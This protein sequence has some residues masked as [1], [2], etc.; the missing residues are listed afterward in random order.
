MPRIN[1]YFPIKVS[2]TGSLTDAQLEQLCESLARALAARISYAE[3]EITTRHHLSTPAAKGMVGEPYKLTRGD[4]ENSAYNVPSYQG[5]GRPVSVSVRRQRRP[6]FIRTALN[7][8][9]TVSDFLDLV[10]LMTNNQSQPSAK[11]LYMDRYEELRWVSLWLVQVNQEYTLRELEVILFA[12]ATQLMHLRANQVLAYAMGT[13]E[14]LR[15]KLILLDRDGVVAR[16]I[17]NMQSHNARRVA[18][19]IDEDVIIHPGGWVL[20]A[21]MALPRVE[22][23]DI[24]TYGP[25]VTVWLPLHALAFIVNG[26]SFERLFGVSWNDHL[27]EYGDQLAPLRILPF[28]TQRRAHFQTLE[29][30]VEPN[31]AE[32]VEQTSAYFGGVHLL[33]QSRIDWLPSAARTQARRLTND[34]TLPLDE[35]R[36]EG[37]WEPNWAGAFIYVV[38]NATGDQPIAPEAERTGQ[39]EPSETPAR[40]IARFTRRMNLD[41]A[42]LGAYLVGLIRRSPALSYYVQRVLDELGSSDRDDVSLAFAQSATNDDLDALARSPNGR[43]LLVRLYDELTSGELGADEQQQAGRVLAARVRSRSIEVVTR[44]L[45]RAGRWVFPYRQ[46]GPTVYDDAPIMAERLADGRIRVS[47][48]HR[49]SGTDMFR[50][51]VRTL[52]RAVFS[53]GLVLDAD[54]WISVKLYDEGGIIV[55]RPALYLLE[56]SNQGATRTLHT[57]GNVIATTATL[58]VGGAAQGASWGVRTLVALDRA[59][60]VLSV[61]GIIVNDHRGWLI[62]T[63][64]EDGRTF[65]R[66]VEVAN[67]LAGVYGLGR[68]A[69]STP[70]IIVD[71]RNAWRSWRANRAYSGLQGADLRRAEEL[72]QNVEQFLTRADEAADAMRREASSTPTGAPAPV[73]SQT[74]PPPGSGSAPRPTTS[75]LPGGTGAA[76]GEAPRAVLYRGTTYR[77]MRGRSRDI[78]DLGDGVYMTYDADLAVLYAQERRVLVQATDPGAPGIVLRVEAETGELGRVLDFY[79]DRALRSDWETFV[80]RQ[81]GG[82]IVLRGGPAEMYNGHFQNWLRSR[83]TSLDNFDVIIGPEY[84]RGGSQVCIRNEGIATRLLDRAEEWARA[85]EPVTPAYPAVRAPRVP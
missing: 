44:R 49:V 51:E 52:P 64:G 2:I 9:S 12:R 73:H 74:S 25:E 71:L 24:L 65:V 54:E 77:F 46:G 37:W 33:N 7:F 82:D 13:T 18:A 68:I 83:G 4:A 47:L 26:E 3:R 30:L 27:N 85:H 5:G 56:I 43:L 42:G 69:F 32:T 67:T 75:P 15:R 39:Q 53:G 84:I 11:V 17:P 57:I 45:G 48:P 10:E 50:E 36:R 31:V 40:L 23:T 79:Y 28:Y 55:Q 14:R 16:E 58:G 1:C 76:A 78:H 63:F 66:T 21:S 38:V 22:E 8:H 20:F 80:A 35:S 6:W 60:T 72:S 70:R 61:I 19:G 59:A 34:V 62:A 29:Y 81:P 41:E